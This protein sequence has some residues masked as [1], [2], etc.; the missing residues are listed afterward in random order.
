MLACNPTTIVKLLTLKA[1]LK[2]RPN[3]ICLPREF[4][5]QSELEMRCPVHLLYMAMYGLTRSN[6]DWEDHVDDRLLLKHLLH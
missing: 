5:T 3:A 6:S 1:R 2:G 4:R